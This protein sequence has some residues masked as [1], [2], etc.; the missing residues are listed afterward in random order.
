MNINKKN[1]MINNIITQIKIKIISLIQ[2][3]KEKIKLKISN[4]AK[5]FKINKIKK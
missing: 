2:I 1:K 5:I 4:K 3:K